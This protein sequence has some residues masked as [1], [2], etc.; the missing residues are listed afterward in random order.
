MEHPAIPDYDEQ[1][2]EVL[3]KLRLL[4]TGPDEGFD[5]IV[6][7][8]SAFFDVP[9]VQ[10]NLVDTDRVWTKSAIGNGPGPLARNDSICAHT[11]LMNEVLC[12]SDL[13]KDPRFSSNK[14][15]INAEP[16]RFYA[17]LPLSVYGGFNVGTL[18]VMDTRARVLK[19]N[20][21]EVLREFSQSVQQQFNLSR[22]EQDG[23]FLVSQTS[24]LNTLLE[25]VADGIVTIDD[26]GIIESLNTTAAHIFGYEP[27]ELVGQEFSKLMPDL[28]RGGWDGYVKHAFD[29][30]NHLLA[31]D[32]GDL[33][34][35]RKE[36][37]LFPMDIS[38]REMFLEG[39]RLFTGIIRDVTDRKVVEDEIKLGREILE[40]TKE[41]I[42]AG[43][44]VFDKNLRLKVVNS[45]A[46]RFL[47]LPAELVDLGTHFQDIMAFLI[48]RGDFGNWN[49]ARK[50]SELKK[51]MSEPKS[52]RFVH[53]IKSDRYVEI[54][55]RSMPGGGFVSTYSDI[56]ARLKNEEKLESLLQQAND[57]NEAKTNFL[58]TISHEIRTPLNGVIGVAHMLEDTD[59]N[60]DQRQKL[61]TILH[62]GNTLLLLINDVLDMNK[63]ESGNLEIEYIV[64]DFR[65]LLE[66]IKA[67]FEL[68]ATIK[69]I[70][71][72]VEIDPAVAPYVIADPTRLR[73][74]IMNLLSNAM[75]FTE[76]GGISLVLRALENSN[77]R[78][79]S[80][81]FS[82]TDTGVGIAEDRQNAIFESFSQ[83]DTSINRKFGGTGLGL[84]IVRSLVTMMDGEI[85]VTSTPG[86]GSCFAA[87]FAFK[88]A[89]DEQITAQEQQIDAA[90]ESEIGALKVLVA[91]DN[92]VN[93]MITR[94]FLE[95]LGH[96]S[97]IAENGQL[98][99]QMQEFDG[100][101]LVL[102]DVHMPVMDGIEATRQIRK[103]KGTDSLPIIGVTAEAFADRH[104]HMQEAGMN[105]VLTKPFTCDQLKS[106]IFKQFSKTDIQILNGKCAPFAARKK[107]TTLE[108]VNVGAVKK[109]DS[110]F[111]ASMSLP[112]GSDEKMA[113]F[114]D[115]LG[116][117]VTCSLIAKTPDAVRS[118]IQVMQ[119]GLSAKDNSVVHR[120]AH[121]IVGVAS[122][123]CAERLVKQAAI[124]EQNAAEFDII[125]GLLP[126]F[127]Q[128]ADETIIWWN[129]KREQ[130]G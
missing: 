116:L 90:E 83:A 33:K 128:T 47:D 49:E 113:D 106:I 87:S 74:I 93:A 120:A 124:L 71:L 59:L 50:R 35:L 39:N 65:A 66:S 57:A 36:G 69:G 115:Q 77:E 102:M 111:D 109:E 55:S 104:T 107:E 11:I 22:L 2:L 6:R 60:E 92:H 20:E 98:A 16:V 127:E 63:I 73:Q 97:E 52:Q 10:I 91:E 114:F 67:P 12:I 122:S 68:E 48:E 89:D 23:R 1:R 94:S 45:Q 81:I 26:T 130:A 4:D 46:T 123:M 117:D 51:I 110:L 56:T 38:I 15:M 121:T 96:R 61:E 72:T 14:L 82:V 42:P 125:C 118:E 37:T 58:S 32:V 129:S 75:K 86:V 19:P 64:C 112:L 27:S 29:T 44:T 24:R 85:S 40:A 100:F 84:S 62:S 103:H 30:G 70:E 95:K 31:N 126:A 105:D 119:E 108:T 21:Y 9:V 78:E 101:D 76:K 25:A 99:V 54:S 5:R 80:V 7:L 17:A 28:G 18:C 34:G 53:V 43:L 13:E 41:N 79:T 88:L 3:N 8:V